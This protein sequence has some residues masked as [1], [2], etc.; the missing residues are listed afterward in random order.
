MQTWLSAQANEKG[1]VVDGPHPHLC[2]WRLGVWAIYCA[3]ITEIL[4]GFCRQLTSKFSNFGCIFPCWLH[5]HTWPATANGLHLMWHCMCLDLICINSHQVRLLGAL[6]VSVNKTLRAPQGHR[7]IHLWFGTVFQTGD[8]HCSQINLGNWWNCGVLLYKFLSGLQR[9]RGP[10]AIMIIQ[11]YRLEHC[12]IW[13]E[14][15][16]RR[17]MMLQDGKFNRLPFMD[18]GTRIASLFESSAS[19]IWKST[20][21]K[22]P[23]ASLSWCY[24]SN[25]VLA[26]PV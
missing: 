13:K 20:R 9:D 16:F 12:V 22:S 24:P 15:L 17:T 14:K 5:L 3:K 19:K 7:N 1:L 26:T 11:K 6:P 23:E 18:L 2:G 4:Q 8:K 10:I 25:K 21:A